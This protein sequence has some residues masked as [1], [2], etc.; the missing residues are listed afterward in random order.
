VIPAAGDSDASE[1][2]GQVFNDD[3]NAFDG[4]LFIFVSED[5][6]I[7]GWQESNGSE[8]VL[9][10]DNSE[11]EAIYKGVTIARDS[12]QRPRLFATDFHGN[13]VDVFDDT[14]APLET[15]GGFVDPD[16]PDGYAPFNVQQV[17]GALIVTYALQDE[18][19]EDDVA[20]AGNGYVDLFDVDGALMSRLVSGGE[21]NAPWGVAFTPPT[22]EA[23]P[24]RLL[25]GNFGD[26]LIH[27]YNFGMLTNNVIMMSEGAL[28][29]SSGSELSIDGLWA[30]G[31]APDS[32]GF[33]GDRLYFTAG[34]EDET[35]GIFGSLATTTLA[36]ST[37]VG[38]STG[39]GGSTGSGGSGPPTGY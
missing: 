28:L 23:A 37:G 17:A 16:L 2:T 1:P 6:G 9:R 32:G 19:G 10:V 3:R 22:F 4:D 29:D 20:G 15:N 12:E 8:A 35:H 5:G 39:T 14:Y 36:G 11:D 34:P 25:I 31:F 30:L 13:K 18:E 38:G 33:S 27:V 26:G 21:L 7:S 24:S